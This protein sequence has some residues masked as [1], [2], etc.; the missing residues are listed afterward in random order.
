MLIV[1]LALFHHQIKPNVHVLKEHIMILPQ[2]NV[3]HVSEDVN[4]AVMA[5]L[6]QLVILLII[7]LLI[8]QTKHVFATLLSF[9]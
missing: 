8:A 4:N 5:L 1:E 3:K 6:V 9:I 7:I 2:T